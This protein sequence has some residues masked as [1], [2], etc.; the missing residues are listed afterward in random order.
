MIFLFTHLALIFTTVV[1]SCVWFWAL[2]GYFQRFCTNVLTFTFFPQ[3]LTFS[4]LIY[5]LLLPTTQLLKL[6]CEEVFIRQVIFTVESRLLPIC[7]HMTNRSIPL[8]A[9]L[10]QGFTS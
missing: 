6:P 2:Q 10:L 9:L 7:C 5:L 3:L 1:F 8:T 4:I